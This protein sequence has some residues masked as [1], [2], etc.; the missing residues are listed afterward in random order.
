MAETQAQA[1]AAPV[2][3]AVS[4]LTKIWAFF[5]SRFT[6]LEVDLSKAIGPSL[7]TKLEADSKEFLDS[8]LGPM[9]LA[10]C[11]D[12]TEIATGKMS[13]SAAI[14]SLVKQAVAS[15]KTLSQEAALQAIALAQNALP[16]NG[17]DGTVTIVA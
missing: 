1:P 7:A 16:V 12:A 3:P 17:T 5:K 10:A 13:V 6:A 11:A 9:A 15:G 8:W 2:A 4:E 14:A